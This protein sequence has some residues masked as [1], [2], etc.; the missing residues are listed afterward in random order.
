MSQLGV[1]SLI[2]DSNMR[3]LVTLR[4]FYILQSL[5][6]F[7]LQ[8]YKFAKDLGLQAPLTEKILSQKS[9]QDRNSNP[10]SVESSA[11]WSVII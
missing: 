11:H 10:G 5:Y 8:M 6:S 7:L 4:K 2:G 1:F 3:N 9:H